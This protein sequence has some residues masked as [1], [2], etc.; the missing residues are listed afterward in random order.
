MHN[1]MS[2]PHD[3]NITH[4]TTMQTGKTKQRKDTTNTH[5]AHIRTWARQRGLSHARRCSA[6]SSFSIETRC[7][8]AAR[9]LECI[10][11]CTSQNH[12]SIEGRDT[13]KQKQKHTEDILPLSERRPLQSRRARQHHRPLCLF[14]SFVVVSVSNNKTTTFDRENNQ[15]QEPKSKTNLSDSPCKNSIIHAVI[16]P[17]SRH[18]TD[19]LIRGMRLMCVF[20]LCL[21]A[22]AAGDFGGEN[23]KNQQPR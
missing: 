5:A 22:S 16:P 20:A 14:R 1:N 10:P 8:G 4:Q 2:T 18:L 21:P 17:Y 12:G 15:S 6:W 11:C 7:V 23:C 19:E 3:R 9:A 13:D